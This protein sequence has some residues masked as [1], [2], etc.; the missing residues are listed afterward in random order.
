LRPKALLFNGQH[1]ISLVL[2][3]IVRFI[4][5]VPAFYTEEHAGIFTAVPFV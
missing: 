4:E 1:Y 3:F 2:K 5:A